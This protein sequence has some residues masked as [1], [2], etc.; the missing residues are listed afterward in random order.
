MTI[1]KKKAV[2]AQ[3]L[4][5]NID[6]ELVA[7]LQVRA[8]WNAEKNAPESWPGACQVTAH[9]KLEKGENFLE[10][11]MREVEEEL[12]NEMVPIIKQLSKTGKLME[13]VNNDSQE[14]QIIT[15]GVIVK[16]NVF[17]TLM[18]KQKSPSFGGFK[19]IQK[20]NIDKIVDIKTIDK[21]TGVTDEN[22]IAMF[23]D[24]KEVLKIAFQ[25]LA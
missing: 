22:I 11:L 20:E 14:K 24:H 17:Q 4:S 21:I 16:E 10:A 3:L 18:K 2:G 15:Y 1:K 23:P 5:K 9:G 7:I 6:G 19:I 13:L 8:K 25:K 12:G